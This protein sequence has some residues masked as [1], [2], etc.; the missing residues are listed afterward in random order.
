GPDP[1]SRRAGL[2]LDVREEATAPRDGGPAIVPGDA[3]ASALVARITHADPEDR[4]PPPEAN[5]AL[6]ER[7]IAILTK[8][9]EQGAEYEPHWAYVPPKPVTPPSV[10]DAGWV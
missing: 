7:Q 6:T 3:G 1:D 8:W 9:V 4:M 10:E 5:R 2:R